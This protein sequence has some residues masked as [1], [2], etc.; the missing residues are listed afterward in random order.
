VSPTDHVTTTRVGSTQVTRVVEWLGPVSTT[1]VLFSSVEEHAWDREA[2][3]LDQIFT[4]RATRAYRCAIQTWV[5][6]TAGITVLVDTGIGNGRH[7]PQVP[8]FENL[9]SDFP[10][11]LAAAGVAPEEVDVV[12]NTHVHYDHVGWNTR[13]DD[14]AST[15]DHDAWVPT[16]PNATYLVPAADVDHFRPENAS[17]MRPAT[18]EEEQRRFEGAALVFADSIAP[19]EAAGQ[20]QPWSGA[21]DLA[22]RLYLRPAPGH[23]PGSSVLWLDDGPGAVFAGDLLHTPVQ[24]LDPGA[25]CAFDLDADAARASRRTVPTGLRPPGRLWC[26][27]TSLATAAPPCATSMTASP[28]SAGWTCLRCEAVHRRRRPADSSRHHLLVAVAPGATP[29]AKRYLSGLPAGSTRL[30]RRWCASAVPLTRHIGR[31]PADVDPSP[32]PSPA[33]RVSTWRR[34]PEG[35][36]ARTRLLRLGH[37]RVGG[38]KPP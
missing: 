33:P 14:V 13:R 17:K 22:E 7:R 1:D 5:L 24:I 19:I 9:S 38:S 26:R 31:G 10:A 2:S 32:P 3:W 35:A 23:T 16:F 27:P 36:P 21:H 6:R 11:R 25:S 30:G 15:N 29:A 28:S 37:R 12:V 8:T 20:L 34:R 18:T 4:N